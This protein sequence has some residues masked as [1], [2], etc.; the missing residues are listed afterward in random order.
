MADTNVY[1]IVGSVQTAAWTVDDDEFLMVKDPEENI[2]TVASID[3]FVDDEWQ[4]TLNGA[5]AGQLGFSGSPNLTVVDAD[6]THGEGGGYSVKNFKTLIDG[7]YAITLE[8]GDDPGTSPRTITIIRNGDPLE[9]PPAPVIEE[10]S[11][12]WYLV[13]DMN[14]WALDGAWKLA[15]DEGSET[16]KGTF[17]LTVA[18][19]SEINLKL[20]TLNDDDPPGVNWALARG[21]SHVDADDPQ[22]EWLDLTDGD[23]AIGIN[24]SGDYMFEFTFVAS[25]DAA[26]NGIITIMSAPETV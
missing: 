21:A 8:T 24:L 17:T 9:E 14:G 2:F 10:D 23:N 12:N 25:V 6:T 4:I 1:R 15:Y 16:Y 20:V 26:V 11:G 18:A 13:G 5:W 22:Q 7:N 19:E 3:M